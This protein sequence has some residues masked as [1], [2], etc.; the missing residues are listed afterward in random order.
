[1]VAEVDWSLNGLSGCIVTVNAALVSSRSI[2]PVK[3]RFQFLVASMS[4]D[5]Q[6]GVRAFLEKRPPEFRGD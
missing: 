1:M 3:G 6:E 2:D 4:S 5:Q